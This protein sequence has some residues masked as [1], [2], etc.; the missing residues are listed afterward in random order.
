MVINENNSHINSFTKG[1]NSDQAFD[2]IQNSQYTFAKNIRITKNQLLGGASD[3]S[4]V[5]EGIV[6]PVPD[7]IQTFIKEEFDDDILSVKCVD[8]LCIIVTKNGGGDLNVYRTYIDEINNRI[9]EIN[10]RIEEIELL[11]KSPGFWNG[12]APKQVSTVLYKE[13]ENVIKLYIS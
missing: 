12:D 1:M 4:S 13:L 10:N 11:W 9:E 6:A 7:G 8:R 2:Q 5:R 3:Y